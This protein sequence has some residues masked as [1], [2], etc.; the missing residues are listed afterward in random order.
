MMNPAS[1][2]VCPQSEVEMRRLPVMLL[3]CLLAACATHDPGWRGADAEPFD[4]AQ[5][6]CET[7]VGALAGPER[8]TAFEACM[9]RK[10]WTR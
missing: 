7:E 6:A 1:H 10:G 5:A 3:S 8:E 2:P 4:R 9:A